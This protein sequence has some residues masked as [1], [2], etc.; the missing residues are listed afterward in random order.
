[1]FTIFKSLGLMKAFLLTFTLF[2][3]IGSVAFGA[4]RLED[5]LILYM[6]FD[7]IDGE[8]VIDHSKYGNHGEVMGDPKHVKGEFGKALQLNG[9]EDYIEIPH[10]KSL[11]VTTEVTV[12]IW[13]NIGRHS[14]PEGGN[15]Q[16]I[17]A[18]GNGPR[19]YS[20]YTHLPSQC[21]HLSIGPAG[22]FGGSV[23]DK[24][25]N[26]NEWTHVV[27]QLDNGT[28]RYYINGEMV[29]EIGGKVDALGNADTEPVAVGSAGPGNIRYL[30]GMIDEVRIWNRALTE[31]EVNDHKE[32]GHFEIFAVDPR[33]KL[34]T[35]WGALK[36]QP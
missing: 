20:F 9:E 16:G 29:K 7:T 1:M 30:L 11:T 4:N 10:D 22:G 15:W 21:L 14:G 3:T 36:D 24:P 28:H 32:K 5:S 23:C 18:K 2:L 12:M 34:T 17:T 6:S 27:A 26:L 8:E 31:D 35:M 13:I 19:S 25:I 33:Q